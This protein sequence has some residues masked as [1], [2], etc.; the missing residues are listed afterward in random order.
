MAK[1]QRVEHSMDSYLSGE[2]NDTYHVAMRLTS[3]NKLLDDKALLDDVEPELK[4]RI[5][6]IQAKEAMLVATSH[7]IW[8]WPF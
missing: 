6:I 5:A 4:E 2:E 8:E 3:L 7:D 1:V